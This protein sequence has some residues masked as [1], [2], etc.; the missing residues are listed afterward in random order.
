MTEREE[1]AL[2]TEAVSPAVADEEVFAEAADVIAAQMRNGLQAENP[3]SSP[4][5]M[6]GPYGFTEYSD[7]RQQERWHALG[8]PDFLFIDTDAGIENPAF[9]RRRLG[10]ECYWLGYDGFILPRL[11]E[12]AA[13]WTDASSAK[14]RSRTFLYPTKSGFIP[15]LAW[16]G[17]RD[18]VVDARC[19]SSVTRLARDARYLADKDIKVAIEGRKAMSWM[20]WLRPKTETAETV[21]LEALA[22]IDRLDAVLG[23]AVK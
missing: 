22:W 10:F 6:G 9:W 7:T 5:M 18:A 1:G 2:P 20:E 8:T 4:N 15:T 17:V 23:K 12:D 21:R 14:M 11:V 16:E 19:L 3:S 13:P